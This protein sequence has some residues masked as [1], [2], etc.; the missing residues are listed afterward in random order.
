MVVQQI[1]W[2]PDMVTS[3]A[4][5]TGKCWMHGAD[6]FGLT[7][8]RSRERQCFSLSCFFWLFGW[9]LVLGFM[10]PAEDCFE[11]TEGYAFTIDAEGTFMASAE[12]VFM[13]VTEGTFMASAEGVF[14]TDT[15]GTFMAPAESVFM[16]DTE[17][18]FKASAEGVFMTDRACAVLGGPR[19]GLIYFLN[20]H[21]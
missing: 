13:I 10:V 12:G 21:A 19:A 16:T 4:S 17:G 3:V 18:T 5:G 2:V 1:P 6:R 11:T 7:S 15:E 14:M 8:T 9:I 20:P